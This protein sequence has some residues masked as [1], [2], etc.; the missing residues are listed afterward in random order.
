MRAG[1]RGGKGGALRGVPALV[2][3]VLVAHGHLVGDRGDHR[4]RPRAGRQRGVQRDQLRLARVR[5][6]VR[7][8]AGVRVRVG[9]R[10]WVRVGAGFRV[11]VR[12][13]TNYVLASER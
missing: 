3:L 9:A 5:V 2:V 8:R 1:A 11:R 10:V 13:T 4:A 12:V 7:V 6:R